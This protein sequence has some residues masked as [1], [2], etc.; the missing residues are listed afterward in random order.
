MTWQQFIERQQEWSEKTFGP[1]PRTQGVTEH[2]EKEI[3]EIR[4]KPFDTEEWIDVILLGLDGYWR[5]GGR[6]VEA[7]LEAKAQKNFAR[8][9][10]VPEDGKAVEHIR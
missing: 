4:A 10:N 5:S 3:A 6:N 1:G 2:I 9:W 7:A 8:K